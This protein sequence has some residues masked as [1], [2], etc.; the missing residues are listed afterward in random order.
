MDAWNQP[1]TEYQKA[2]IERI[3]KSLGVDDY[4]KDPPHSMNQARGMLYRLLKR[5]E[6]QEGKEYTNH[7]TGRKAPSLKVPPAKA[8]I[9]PKV[10]PIELDK[11]MVVVTLIRWAIKDKFSGRILGLPEQT[12]SIFNPMTFN[13]RENARLMKHSFYEAVGLQTQVIKVVVKIEEI[14]SRG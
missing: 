8:K 6:E 13:D 3:S 2:A 12:G 9:E 1:P 7:A 14:Y 10:E 11:P 4:I 5:L